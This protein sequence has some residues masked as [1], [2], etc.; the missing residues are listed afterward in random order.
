MPW[1]QVQKRLKA[2]RRDLRKVRREVTA[3]Q[4][5][6]ERWAIEMA[7]PGPPT[8]VPEVAAIPSGMVLDM[9]M[10]GYRN[11]CLLYFEH[12]STDPGRTR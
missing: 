4:V 8:L 1:R 3:G 5:R 2:P 11:A 7:S 12:T 6:R 10:R 9:N